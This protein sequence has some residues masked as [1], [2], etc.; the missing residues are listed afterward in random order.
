MTLSKV[1]LGDICKVKGGFAF[2]STDFTEQG[3]PVIKIAN[4]LDNEVKV[5]K[6]N[7]YVDPSYL[8]KYKEFIIG[9]DA[10]LIALSGATTG[11]FGIYQSQNK[12]LLNQ[13]VA[14]LVPDESKATTKF[15]YYCLKGLQKRI[16]DKASGA[17][18]PNISTREI[19]D[20]EVELG[21]TEYQEKVT[22]I[23]DK[24]KILIDIRKA[25]IEALSSLKQSVFLE[26]F[27]D[28][29]L[30]SKNWNVNKF[31][32]LC[33]KITDGKH[34]DCRNDLNSGYYFLSAKDI[35]KEKIDYSNARQILR[36]DFEEVH[37]RTDIEIGDLL[38][39]NT[40]ATI[41]K[42]AIVT[43]AEKARK[44]TLQKSVAVIK[45]KPNLLNSIFLIQLLHFKIEMLMNA[46]SG[47]AQKNLL[48]NQL[49]NFNVIV[50]PLELQKKF[51]KIAKKIERE[52]LLNE[53][54]LEICT[55]LYNSLIQRAF[56]G[57]LFND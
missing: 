36:E 6:S 25:Q 38:L 2:K 20:F 39:V 32:E 5:N 52:K 30:N 50:P 54:S 33:N 53:Q 24:A 10:L 34:G 16:F 51:A 21:D 43:D 29:N 55:A 26:M 42:S 7:S 57:E 23:L 4:I 8:E 27:G 22:S 49:K 11:K 13:R 15:I 45:I 19:E 41:G 9:K 28:P 17:A 44:T 40:G 56:K 12:A 35:N 47:S 1:K 46:A 48:L 14:M 37:K 3:I 18:Q 31:G